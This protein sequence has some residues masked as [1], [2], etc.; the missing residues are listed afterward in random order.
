MLTSFFSVFSRSVFQLVIVC[1]SSCLFY[2]L[3][4]LAIAKTRR[5]W[6]F[7]FCSSKTVIWS[8]FNVNWIFRA[9]SS[10]V[11]KDYF[12]K[13]FTEAAASIMM[14]PKSIIKVAASGKMRQKWI[15]K[16]RRRRREHYEMREQKI[17][18]ELLNIKQ[19]CTQ[20]WVDIEL[21]K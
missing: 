4:P 14:M 15:A 20:N 12:S 11:L 1:S 10:W 7:G 5:F 17:V 8:F 2:Q 18:S 9:G 3:D 16:K 13:N 6:P 21:V 19:I